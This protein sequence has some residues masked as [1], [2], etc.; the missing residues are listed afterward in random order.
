MKAFPECYAL[1]VEWRCVKKAAL[2]DEQIVMKKAQ[3]WATQRSL[4]P[5]LLINLSIASCQKRAGGI[6][7]NWFNL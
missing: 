3:N 4:K 6:S 7:L 1:S 2:R 5:V